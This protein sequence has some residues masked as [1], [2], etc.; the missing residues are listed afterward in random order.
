[1]MNIYRRWKSLWHPNR[2]HGWGRTRSYFEGW[3]YKFVSQDESLALAFIPG[4]AMSDQGEQHCFIQMIDGTAGKT[5]YERFPVEDFETS[6]DQFNVRIG[7]NHFDLNGIKINLPFIKGELHLS[8]TTPWPPQLGAPGIM[9]WYSFVPMMQCYHGVVSM[10]HNVQGTLEYDGQTFR[11]DNCPGYIEKDWGTSFP[12]CWIWMQSNHFEDLS[13]KVSIMASVA[14]IP[15]LGRYFIGHLLTLYID[16]TFYKFTTYNGSAY[17][18]EL[19]EEK[20][21]LSFKRK[22]LTLNIEA[23]KGHT[24]A[25]ISPIQG[26]MSGKVNESIASTLHISLTQK[27][28][29]I[30]KGIGRHSGLEVGGEPS[31]LLTSEWV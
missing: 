7:D 2:Y 25:L 18:A 15:W 21:I 24:G 6:P 23:I 27:G 29:V 17:K 13:S 9:G 30:Y 14:H 19:T 10:H 28:Q 20:V 1:M 31:V 26:D 12:K 5:F 16:G 3:Y 8:N 4:I 11:F 22:D